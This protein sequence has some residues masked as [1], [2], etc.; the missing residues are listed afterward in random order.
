MRNKQNLCG[1]T[2]IELLVVISIIA[3]L[4]AVSIGVFSGLQK[5]GRDAKRKSDLATIQSALEQY[6]ADQNYYPN[7]TD[8]LATG[9]KKYL[10]TV[11]VESTS[12]NPSY[13]YLP[14]PTNCTTTSTCTNYQLF[15]KLENN[16]SVNGV[17]PANAVAPSYNYTVSP[18]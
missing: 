10:R 4:V 9:S 2:L 7:S 17:C 14:S 18:P 6:H 15:A 5:S 13:C 3:I 12:T 11:P 1:F 16:D 8:I